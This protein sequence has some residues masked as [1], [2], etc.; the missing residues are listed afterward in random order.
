MDK[1]LAMVKKEDRRSQIAILVRRAK[2]PLASNNAHHALSD[3][4][5]AQRLQP[6]EP[7]VLRELAELLVDGPPE[8]Q[9]P[10]QA[11]QLLEQLSELES[12]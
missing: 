6:D 7:I 3:L 11:K 12:R 4:R 1:A 2:Y 10:L 5:Q 9:D 8:I